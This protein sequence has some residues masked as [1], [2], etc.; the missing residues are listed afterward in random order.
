MKVMTI[1]GTRPE[2]I[3]LSRV[4]AELD[5]HFE[6]IL[7]HTGQN[8]DH[9]LNGI[10]FEQMGLRTPDEILD[11]A[12]ASP[13]HT[14]SGML[15]QVDGLLGEHQPD[16]VLILG[17]TNSC[18]AAAYAAKRRHI[19]IFHMEAGN[20]CF[21][22]RVP[23]EINRKIVDHISDINMPYTEHARRNLLTEGLPADCIIKT[24]SPMPEV[25]SHYSSEIAKSDVLRRL[26]LVS[27]GY[28]VVSAHREE[29]VDRPTRLASLV[30]T[31]NQLSNDAPV[32]LSIHPRTRARLND[33]AL[34]FSP[35][36]IQHEPFGFFDYV[37]LQVYSCC[38]ISDSGTITEE[39][40]IL[41]FPAVT[42]R[43]THERQEGSDEG[44][45]IMADFPDVLEAVK[46]AVAQSTSGWSPRL[47][48][49][50]TARDVSKKV[51]RT[52]LS[53]T[54]YVNRVIWRK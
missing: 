10:F 43:Q 54:S 31:V 15:S 29:N 5:M 42:I 7:V 44:T 37:K 51:V 26:D 23:E 3:K 24:G 1:V 53:Y 45:V 38:V 27:G 35:R 9:Y 32:V 47:P 12:G 18:V 30:A 22:Q 14:I 39:S 40:A 6:H 4:M 19:P 25:L 8:Y 2:I 21:D 13:I 48:I 52:I 46:V 28:Y 17:D 20:R 33:V 34:S 49:D 50:Y 16:A 11:C 36:V 41:G